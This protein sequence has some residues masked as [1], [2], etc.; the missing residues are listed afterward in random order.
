MKLTLSMLRFSQI[1]L[2]L[3]FAKP[4]PDIE[5]NIM[6]EIPINVKKI[7]EQMKTE[8]ILEEM[9]NNPD[10]HLNTNID[11]ERVNHIRNFT[12]EYLNNK[13]DIIVPLNVSDINLTLQVFKELYKKLEEE[14]K[15]L[16]QKAYEATS[17]DLYGSKSSFKK[18]LTTFYST[19]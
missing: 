9:F 1:I 11:Q 12:N 8:R 7:V 13:I 15:Q 5:N 10:I 16:Q 3:K 14:N 19:L 6:E 4:L 17:A 18:V 2:G